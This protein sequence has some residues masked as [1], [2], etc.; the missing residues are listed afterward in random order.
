MY[1]TIFCLCRH[2]IDPSDKLIL[3][4]LKNLKAERQKNKVNETATFSGMFERG[5]M[6]V[7][8]AKPAAAVA[9]RGSGESEQVRDGERRYTNMKELSDDI[10]KMRDAL[11]AAEYNGNHT[12]AKMLRQRI[13]K[14]EAIIDVARQKAVQKAMPD[15]SNPSE[16]DI[17]EAKEHGLDLTDKFVREELQ[18]L[19]REKIGEA[20]ADEPTNELS[21]VPV[22][23]SWKRRAAIVGIVA[24]LFSLCRN[25]YRV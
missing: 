18:R 15:W 5:S 10:A 14:V 20:D 12:E 13:N 19:S 6:S 23:S 17:R 24:I 9:P 11:S 21:D 25:I 2:K 4:Q 1:R 3:K 22:A 16:E 8:G 7:P